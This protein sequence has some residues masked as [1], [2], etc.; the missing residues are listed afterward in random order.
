MT[1]IAWIQDF[2]WDN[3]NQ[4]LKMSFGNYVNKDVPLWGKELGTKKKITF[5]YGSVTL[6]KN[7]IILEP[8]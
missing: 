8:A 2:A 1:Q 6:E 4:V 7:K 5:N 3:A